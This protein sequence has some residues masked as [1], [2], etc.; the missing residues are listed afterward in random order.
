MSGCWL[1]AEISLW[2]ISKEWYSLFLRLACP[3]TKLKQLSHGIDV[4]YSRESNPRMGEHGTSQAVETLPED[5][6]ESDFY[7]ALEAATQK[8]GRLGWEVGIAS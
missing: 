3:V 1:C 7:G 5:F 2:R 6:G 8:P 4:V